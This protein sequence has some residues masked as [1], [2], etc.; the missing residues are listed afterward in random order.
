MALS[1][2]QKQ[3]NLIERL[4]KK[5]DLD[6]NRAITLVASNLWNIQNTDSH[7]YKL[8]YFRNGKKVNGYHITD[9]V[10]Q[11]YEQSGLFEKTSASE[12]HFVMQYN[13]KKKWIPSYKS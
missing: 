5:C 12:N 6:E 2:F 8:N 10:Y 4:M 3:C 13:P 1:I 11:K 9:I 7:E